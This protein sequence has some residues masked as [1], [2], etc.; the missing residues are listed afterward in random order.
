M[1]RFNI[2]A[3]DGHTL[4]SYDDEPPPVFDRWLE[5]IDKDDAVLRAFGD[6]AELEEYMPGSWYVIDGD[7]KVATMHL[8]QGEDEF[9][10]PY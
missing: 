6:E 2:V 8:D 1:Q 3:L 5:A 10:V 9:G 4:P 7:E